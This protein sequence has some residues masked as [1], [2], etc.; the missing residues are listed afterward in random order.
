MMILKTILATTLLAFVAALKS[1]APEVSCPVYSHQHYDVTDERQVLR[2]CVSD[3][4]GQLD[5]RVRGEDDLCD[6]R[7][8][9]GVIDRR[10]EL[11]LIGHTRRSRLRRV[12]HQPRPGEGQRRENGDESDLHGSPS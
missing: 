7:V 5:H 9:I 10:D 4:C 3:L 1:G 6:R 2:A 8:A 12:G 11:S